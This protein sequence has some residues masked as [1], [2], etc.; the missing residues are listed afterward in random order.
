MKNIILFLV[1]TL[2]YLLTASTRC[3][4]QGISD[5]ITV[6]VKSLYNAVATGDS[7]DLCKELLDS[8]RTREHTKNKEIFELNQA[9]KAKGEEAKAL[10]VASEAS[11]QI[12]LR[13]EGM[14][15]AEKRRGLLRFGLGVLVGITGYAIFH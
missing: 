7:L 6:S 1:V 15:R 12:N 11:R 9:L 10:M 13:T 14:L 3:T 2:V 5:S 8:A 4:A